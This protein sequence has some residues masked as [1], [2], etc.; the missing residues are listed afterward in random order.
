VVFGSEGGH[1]QGSDRL[2][3]WNQAD[4][5]MAGQDSSRFAKLLA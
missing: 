4:R 1:Q 5:D 3:R 2:S